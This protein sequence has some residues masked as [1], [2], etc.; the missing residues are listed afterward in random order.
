[1]PAPNSL[2]ECRSWKNRC[3]LLH[4]RAEGSLREMLDIGA[5]ASIDRALLMINKPTAKQASAIARWRSAE[6]E[7]DQAIQLF[8]LAKELQRRVD[9]DGAFSCLDC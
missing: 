3:A 2:L 5:R 1:M 9:L 4:A 8:D 7:L 6:E